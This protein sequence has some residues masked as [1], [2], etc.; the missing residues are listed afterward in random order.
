MKGLGLQQVNILEAISY[1]DENVLIDELMTTPCSKEVRIVMQRN[2]VMRDHSSDFPITLSVLEGVVKLTIE[3]DEHVVKR[4]ELVLLQ[5]ETKHHLEAL[6]NSVLRLTLFTA[7]GKSND[8]GV[9]QAASEK[10]F[11]LFRGVVD[12]WCCGFTI[13]E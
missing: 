7:T 3:E 1:S 6:D 10:A 13:L 9:D 2:Q 5:A 4:G 12:H 8:E 11:A